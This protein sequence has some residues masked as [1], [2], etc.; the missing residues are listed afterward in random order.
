MSL[1]SSLFHGL[2]SLNFI[3][4]T[5]LFS[6]TLYRPSSFSINLH[7]SSVFTCPRTALVLISISSVIFVSK[8]RSH[9]LS[10]ISV[11]LYRSQ[12][13]WFSRSFPFYTYYSKSPIPHSSESRLPI[14]TIQFFH[15]SISI[16]YPLRI[17]DWS[18]ALRA[19]TL[20]SAGIFK[21]SMR[22][23]NRL[24]IGLSYRPARLHRLAESIPSN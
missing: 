16:F 12:T 10:V 2:S 19:C 3:Y 7:H 22:A 17:F 9:C 18:G 14:P 6:I 4:P 8:Y 20:Y 24:G 1:L 15:H 21:Q 11:S 5:L 13:M 23:R